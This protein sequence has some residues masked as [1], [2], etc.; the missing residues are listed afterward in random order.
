MVIM[1]L[2]LAP[3]TWAGAE[4]V[5]LILVPYVT[6]SLGNAQ[7]ARFS[8]VEKLGDMSY[9]TYLYGFLVQQIIAQMIGT[10]GAHWTNFLVS[11]PITL[12]LGFLSWRLVEKPAIALKPL[13]RG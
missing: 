12:M 2:P 6:L 5:S 7:N 11:A 10:L 4:I 9:G 8:W 1:L 13:K 3:S